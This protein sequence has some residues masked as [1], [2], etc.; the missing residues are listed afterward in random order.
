[1]LIVQ[2]GI[3]AKH[4]LK[5]AADQ[6]LL[7]GVSVQGIVVNQQFTPSRRQRLLH[8]ADILG[9]LFPPLGRALAKAVRKSALE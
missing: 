9:W 2:Q 6:L 7:A 3:T 8:L 4:Q 5:Q 1:V